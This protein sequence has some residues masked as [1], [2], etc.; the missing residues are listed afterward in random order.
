MKS[1][2]LS[3]C[4]MFI[5]RKEDFYEYC[6]WIFS[7]LFELENR[8]NIENYSVLQKRIYGFISE[9][10][11][12]VWLD[13]KQL[14]K[15]ELPILSMEHDSFKVICKKSYRRIMKIKS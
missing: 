15:C 3:I 11:F 6:D 8:V 7:I 2:Q 5:M 1:K 13:K 12:N 10:L 9:R 4:N 14:D